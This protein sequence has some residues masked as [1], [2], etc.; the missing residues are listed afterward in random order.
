MFLISYLG[1]DKLMPS[2]QQ[3]NQSPRK[4]YKIS[5]STQT[6]SQTHNTDRHLQFPLKEEKEKRQVI[7]P[8]IW[9]QYI[10]KHTNKNDQ[11]IDRV[12]CIAVHMSVSQQLK[13]KQNQNQTNRTACF[14]MGHYRQQMTQVYFIQTLKSVVLTLQV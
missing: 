13:K 14:N 3:H 12:F 7:Q 8:F 4:E 2:G 9:T 6:L 10:C 5:S 1:E 11:K